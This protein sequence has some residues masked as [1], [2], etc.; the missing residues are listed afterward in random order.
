MYMIKSNYRAA[1]LGLML[2]ML[3]SNIAAAVEKGSTAPLFSLP[4]I[5]QENK[6]ALGNYKGKVVYLDFWASWCAPCRVSFPLLN[7]LYKEKKNR[8]FEIIAINLDEDDN[9]LKR[10]LK[11]ISVDFTLLRDLSNKVPEMY[12]V[13]A[14]PSSFII[15]KKGQIRYVHKG[16]KRSDMAKIEQKVEQLLNE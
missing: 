4:Q 14:M 15:D 1:L 10:F 5:G 11:L 7:T 16:F 9:D 6:I 3:L 8:G 2:A 13:E 12:A